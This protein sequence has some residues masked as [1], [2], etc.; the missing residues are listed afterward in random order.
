M[1]EVFVWLPG[2]PAQHHFFHGVAGHVAVQVSSNYYSFWPGRGKKM[3]RSIGIFKAAP[4]DFS[5]VSYEIDRRDMG[6]ERDAAISIDGLN[7]LAM[8]NEWDRIKGNAT[9]YELLSTNCCTVSGRLL[10]VGLVNTDKWQRTL[11]RQAGRWLREC[12]SITTSVSFTPTVAMH[13][14]TP[15]VILYFAMLIK[16]AN[17]GYSEPEDQVLRRVKEIYFKTH[18]WQK[19]FPSGVIARLLGFFS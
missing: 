8:A 16:N 17:E 3:E 4:A 14:I 12:L 5:K 9:R 18:P 10:H 19:Y 1:A 15:S 2:D 11:E 6:Y 13:S 7:E